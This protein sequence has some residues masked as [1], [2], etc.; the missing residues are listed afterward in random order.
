MSTPNPVDSFSRYMAEVFDEKQVIAVPTAFQAFFGKAGSETIYSPD[1][2]DVDIDIVRGNERIAALIPRDSVSRPL[3]S[4]QKNQ[5]AENYSSFSRKYP[6]AEEEGDITGNQ[7]LRRVAGENSYERRDRQS[8]MRYLARKHHMESIRRIVRMNEVLAAQ[9]V[10]TGFQ[11]AIIGTTNANLKYDFRRNANLTV[12]PTNTWNSGSQDILGDI[13]GICDAIREY[14]KVNPDMMFLGGD[15]MAALLAD[16]DVKDKADNRRFEL[17]QISSNAPVPPKYT[18]WIDSGWNARGYLRTPKGYN[19]WMFTNVDGYTNG[20]GTF[21]KYMPED[22]VL[23]SSSMARADR[24]F[25]PPET[26]PQVPS[27]REL[28]VEMFGINP[29]MPLMPNNI[30]NANAIIDPSMFYCDAYVSDGWKK[31]TIRTQEAPIFATT[32]TDGFGLLQNLIT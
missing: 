14:G 20:A 6:L 24:Y 5:N 3:G 13:D 30:K 7:L 9:S 12:T 29:D 26:L 15:A 25:G 10:L 27:R 23:V 11:D 21:T 32:Q 31:V 18:R 28:Y 17:I 19:L 22:Q 16:T 1:S 8:R 4:T 2:N